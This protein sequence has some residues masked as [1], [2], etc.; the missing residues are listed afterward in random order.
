[1]AFDA[2]ALMGAY[3][4]STLFRY[5]GLAGR[6]GLGPCPRARWR[7][8][9]RAPRERLGPRRLPRAVRRRHHRRDPVPRPRGHR[10]RHGRHRWSTRS[11]EPAVA[12][13]E[14]PAVGHLP[15]P[16]PHA[17]RSRP[18]ALPDRPRLRRRRPARPSAPCSSAPA[19]PAAAS[20]CS[21]LSHPEAGL[22]PV[23]FLDDD[24]WKRQRR[25][26][27]VPRPRHARRPR[28]GRPRDGRRRR[29]G[30]HPERRQG[31]VIKRDRRRGPRARA[32]PSRC[33]RP[34]PSPSPTRAD[35]RDVR[36]VDMRDILGRAA[37][38]TDLAAI[39]GYVTGKRVLVTGAGGSIGSELC[40]QLDK[41]G[42]AELIMLDRDESA[43][44]ARAALDP[45]PRAARQRRGRPQRH[46]R[47][48]RRCGGSSQERRPEV[49][50]HAAALKHL[51]MLEQYPHEA[52]KT[53]VLGT[54]NVLRGRRRG[55]RDHLRQHL[56]RQGRRPQE[57]PGLL[58]AHRRAAHRGD[59]PARPTAPTSASASAT[60]SAAAAR[61]C[62]PSPRRSRA[63]GPV[64]VTH[65]DITR[66]FMTVE[67]A[68]QLV[69]QAGA[70]GEDG[71]VM[72][73]DMGQPVKIVD[74][75][76]QLIDAVRART[77]RSS[78][79]ACARARSSTSSSSAAPRAT[80]APSTPWS[81]TPQVSPL[82]PD[83]VRSYDLD[84]HAPG[85][86]AGLRGLGAPA[87]PVGLASSAAGSRIDGDAC[88]S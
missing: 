33:C 68:V 29:R 85:H 26:Y 14:R 22:L 84:A 44:H 51:P 38:E 77:S 5:D 59:G 16:L 64:T 65:P 81:R 46:P 70:I 32:S 37:I 3:L 4:L 71:E 30:R 73:L 88:A 8:G 42:P 28:A 24:P 12:R 2:V 34:S 57:R 48:C 43:L 52:M 18:V 87:G 50:F 66:Y 39:A 1:M 10:R 74:V 40:R 45:R 36:D 13:A 86:A 69:I 79:P 55:R 27:G 56:H 21:M 67:E 49:V 62:T 35:V 75:A 23:G 80:S 17:H 63:G 83:V 9:R 53:N 47:R 78:T 41:F 60:C 19:P 15:R 58:Q 54:A 82:S 25:H 76:R 72:I 20:R 31:D 61:C 6:P 7:C 11:A